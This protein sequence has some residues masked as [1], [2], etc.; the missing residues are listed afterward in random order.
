MCIYFIIV[1]IA[2][3]FA[4]LVKFVAKFWVLRRRREPSAMEAVGEFSKT[5]F[6]MYGFLTCFTY[7]QLTL[8]LGFDT[9]RRLNDLYRHVLKELFFTQNVD[10][11]RRP[12][13]LYHWRRTVVDMCF[14]YDTVL[15]PSRPQCI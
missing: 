4:S 9:E 5:E 6:S 14:I 1:N 7:I 15:A 3:V 12:S 2:P 8:D 10:H 13:P 11:F